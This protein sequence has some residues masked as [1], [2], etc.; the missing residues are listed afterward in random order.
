MTELVDKN[1][2]LKIWRG[3]WEGTMF[4]SAADAEFALEQLEAIETQT[5]DHQPTFEVGEYYQTTRKGRPYI[6]RVS[7]D[8]GKNLPVKC[9]AMDSGWFSSDCWTLRKMEPCEP[10]TV[11]Q[12]ATFKRAEIKNDIDFI[13]KD[14]DGDWIEIVENIED[15]FQTAEELREVRNVESNK[16]S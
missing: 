9:L 7:K 11:E 15:Y 1:E 6:F 3:Y 5:A 12:I 2:V 8:F 13:I 14:G 4:N 16:S 10:A